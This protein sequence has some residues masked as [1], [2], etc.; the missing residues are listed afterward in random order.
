M[1]QLITGEGDVDYTAG[2]ARDRDDDGRARRSG[3]RPSEMRLVD[4]VMYMNMGSMHAAASSSSSTSSDP[5]TRSAVARR[6]ACDP[7]RVHRRARAQRCRRSPTSAPTEVDGRPLPGHASTP[8]AMMAEHGPGR[9]RDARGLPKTMTVRH[10]VRQRGPVQ[11]DGHGHGQDGHQRTMT[12][13]DCGD[14]VSI[15]APPADRDHGDAGPAEH[16]RPSAARPAAGSAQRPRMLPAHALHRGRH[17]PLGHRDVRAVGVE[18]LEAGEDV[19]HLGGLD[20][21]L[22]AC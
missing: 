1:G 18:R 11:P 6:T 5:T 15:E 7:S 3:G 12:L 14:D 21:T 8:R 22:R 2:L 9:P 13:S 17:R 10:V 16:G 19:G 4:N 20:L